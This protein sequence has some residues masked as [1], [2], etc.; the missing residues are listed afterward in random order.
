MELKATHFWGNT[1]SDPHFWDMAPGALHK[2]FSA[3]SGAEIPRHGL[4]E[5]GIRGKRSIRRI[6][7][8]PRRD[9]SYVGANADMNTDP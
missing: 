8:T 4:M 2:C 1:Y 6:R 9:S 5:E 7:L 3:M